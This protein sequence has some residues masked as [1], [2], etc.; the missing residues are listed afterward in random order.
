MIPLMDIEL[1]KGFSFMVLTCFLKNF[2][3]KE[4]VG[5]FLA[6][7]IFYASVVL[8]AQHHGFLHTWYH[9]LPCLFY[10]MPFFFFRAV[11]VLGGSPWDVLGVQRKSFF[12]AGA[13]ERAM[14]TNRG[15][16][17]FRVPQNFFQVLFC[18]NRIFIV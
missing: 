4:C 15:M 5:I 3:Q 6:Q 1:F 11:A 7:V 8:Q 10:A 13:P 14:V 18:N 12:N 17:F 16:L 9:F 2:M